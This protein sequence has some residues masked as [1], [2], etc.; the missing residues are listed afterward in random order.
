MTTRHRMSSVCAGSASTSTSGGGPV[1]SLARMLSSC[2]SAAVPEAHEEWQEALASGS[3]CKLYSEALGDLSRQIKTVAVAGTHGKTSTTALTVAGMR[4]GGL[5]PSF[6]VGGNVPELGGNGFA[7]SSPYFVVESCEFNRSFHALQPHVA[8]LLNLET[9]HFDC[10]ASF[11]E[12]VQ[13]FA[14]FAAQVPSGGTVLAHES[15]PEEALYDVQPGVRVHRVRD[16]QTGD[17]QEISAEALVFRSGRV[18]F[19]PVL[20]GRRLSRI[21]LRVLG[22]FQ[23]TNALFALAAAAICGAEAQSAAEGIGRFQGVARRLER[24]ETRRGPLL[25]DYAHHPSEIRVVLEA[26]RDAFPGAPYTSASSRISTR[27]R[28]TS[29]VTSRERWRWPIAVC[30]PISSPR[31]KTHTG[32]MAYLRAIWPRP[33]VVMAERQRRSGVSI[34]SGRVCGRH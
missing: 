19:E 16:T 23:A 32:S 2:V 27:V 31:G 1:V 33:F 21:S 14:R 20:F 4:G 26:V 6:L 34:A 17:G 10:Y 12:L 11:D 25:F 5:D 8:M 13:S 9:D 22:R 15:V 30:L 18:S 3:D 29:S 28:G 24:I 7:G